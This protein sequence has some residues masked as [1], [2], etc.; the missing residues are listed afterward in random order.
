MHFSQFRNVLE[1]KTSGF[2]IEA[3]V[4]CYGHLI[5]ETTEGVIL[6]DRTETLYES[7]D[8]AV[9][10]IKQRRLQ[11]DISKQIQQE[12]YEEMSDRTVADIIKQ[13]HTT[14]RVTDTL[15]E[16]YVE[17][18]SS[19]LFTTDAVAQDIRKLNDLDRIVE[20]RFD[21]VLDD[22][23]K[24]VISEAT[25]EKLNNVF[26]QHQDIVEYMRESASNFLTV[27]DQLEE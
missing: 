11:E 8:A 26:S 25:Q 10:A 9:Q 17:L 23:S 21:Y 27:L 7:V 3:Q 2:Q 16:S 1:Q 15:I 4:S 6:I 14:V 18:A 19:K 5:Q 24:I 20:G 13:H 22:G 12:I